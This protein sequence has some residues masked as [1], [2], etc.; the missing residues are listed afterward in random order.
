MPAVS[1]VSAESAVPTVLAASSISAAPTRQDPERL[2]WSEI[3]LLRDRL[4]L[5]ASDAASAAP[6]TTRA[7]STDFAV[8]RDRRT[9]LL[10]RVQRYGALFPGGAHREEALRVELLTLFEL[11]SLAGGDFTALRERIVET[12]R[13]PPCPSAPHEAAYWAT[14]TLEPD[15]AAAQ[16]SSQPHPNIPSGSGAISS[17][18]GQTASPGAAARFSRSGLAPLAR[19]GPVPPDRRLAAGWAD[20]VRRYPDSRYTP[21]LTRALFERAETA[22]DLPAM[23]QLAASMEQNFPERAVTHLLAARLR[24]RRAVGHPFWLTFRAGEQAIDTRRHAGAPVLIVVWSARDQRSE[25]L[26][27]E[28][29]EFC[30]GWPDVAVFGVC[31]DYRPDAMEQFVR[32]TAVDWPQ[33][34]DGRG[35]ANEFALTWGVTDTPTVFVVDRAGQLVGVAAPATASSVANAWKTLAEQALEN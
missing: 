28:V 33:C 8:A 31:L 7:T 4:T 19:P 13:H 17:L 9:A 27:R 14:V 26:C 1:A 3:R 6:A 2:L 5:D 16:A 11:G 21:R 34:F 32:Q 35:P 20:Y 22:G 12:L 10:R 30:A 18:N 25:A 24:R 29:A 23:E 15:E